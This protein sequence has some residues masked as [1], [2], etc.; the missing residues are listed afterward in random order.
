[1]ETVFRPLPERIAIHAAARPDHAALI[2]GGRRVT[3]GQLNAAMDRVAAALQAR[4]LCAQD[5][6]AICSSSS[7]AYVEVF[8][9][10][11]RAGVAVAPLSPGSTA[12]SL[13]GMVSDCGA[14]TLFLDAAAAAH[15]A[16]S[17]QAIAAPVVTLDGDPSGQPLEAWLAAA[18]ARPSSLAIEPDWAFNIIYSSGTTGAPKG[19]VQPHVMRTPF[20]TPDAPFGYGPD[21][22]VIISTG[23][24][25]NTT[26]VSLF[27]CLGGGGTVVLMARFDARAFLELAERH[28]ATHAMLV[29]VQY[30][31]IMA[32]PEFDR[33]DLSAF[34]M[35]F[36]TSA[37]FP[38]HLKADVLKRWPGGLT[39]YYGM[40]EGGG[41]RC[42][43]PTRPPTSCTPWVSPGRTSTCG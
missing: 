37:P 35:K 43:T 18:P 25:S 26:L 7:I 32:D 36:C 33:F 29:P 22:V 20:D 2:Q 19:I 3:F 30:Q 13:A 17:R 16:P 10:A 21:A 1:M 38:A 28:R 39:E 42:S 8:C 23:L 11:L 34:R 4:G 40:T 31:R 24:Y 14:R 41:G 9:G 12:E 5:V 27:P 15:L 6:V